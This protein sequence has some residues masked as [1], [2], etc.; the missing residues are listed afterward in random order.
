MIGLIWFGVAR[1]RDRAILYIL[2]IPNISSVLYVMCFAA[3]MWMKTNTE[4]ICYDK[5][6][7]IVEI[8]DYIYMLIE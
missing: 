8:Y 4:Q 2:T 1:T 6:F 5:Q 3:S 7:N